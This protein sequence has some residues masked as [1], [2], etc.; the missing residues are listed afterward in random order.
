MSFELTTQELAAYKD[1]GFIVRPGVFAQQEIEAFRLGA[2][3]ALATARAMTATPTARRYSLDGNLFVDVGHVTVQFEHSLDAQKIRVIEPV[4]HLHEVFEALVDDARLVQPMCQLIGEDKVSLWTAKFNAKSPEIG[5]GFGWHQ[6]SP[7]WVHDNEDVAR[8]PNV[9]LNF[10]D[11]SIANGCLHL[12][13]GSHKA[14]MLPGCSDGR[15]LAGF[16]TDPNFVNED[17]QVPI[18]VPAGSLVFFDPLVVHGSP[19]NTSKQPR[20]GIILTYQ[21]WGRPTL[22]R[23]DVRNAGC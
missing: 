7:Y 9:M 14:G 6:D 20:R 3:A 23:G 13:R 15:Q 16:Y 21:P 2:D 10:D 18:E 19:A 12:I 1:V 22:K 17:D 8:L 11:S 5:S 4:H